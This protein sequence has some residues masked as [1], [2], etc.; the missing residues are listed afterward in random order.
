MNST[1]M[2]II[3][4][5]EDRNQFALAKELEEIEAARKTRKVRVKRKKPWATLPRG[6]TKES[7]DKF[8]RSLTRKTKRDPKGFVRECMRKLKG[9][10]IK[11]PARF[12]ASLK[13]QYLG[14]TMW[15]PGRGGYKA[16]R[17]Y[18]K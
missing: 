4:E 11:D 15:R 13:D 16:S 9:T 1:M 8:A 2:D 12:C 3:E 7:L 18:R 6:W 5:L 10:P 14:T 17:K